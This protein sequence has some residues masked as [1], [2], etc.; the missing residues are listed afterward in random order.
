MRSILVVLLVVGF[1]S[2]GVGAAGADPA[3]LDELLSL[4]A[5]ARGGKARFEALRALRLELQ[6]EEATF[7][8]KGIYVA[9]KDG[10]MRVDIYSG[11]RRVFTEALGPQ[12][13]WQWREGDGEV[14]RLTD[15]AEGALRRGLVSNLYASYQWPEQGYRLSLVEE[16]KEESGSAPAPVLIAEESDGFTRQLRIDPS[17]HRVDR[18]YETSALHPDLD[19]AKTA[20]YSVTRE[21]MTVE[22]IDIPRSIEKIDEAS[23][24]V[25]QRSTVL[26]ASLALA[27]RA[28]P[29]WARPAQFD[30][31]ALPITGSP[32]D[33]S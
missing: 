12:G 11:D 21:W 17:T 24:E 32:G 29:A 14:S 10:Y 8:V 20:Q 4:N 25:I 22:G 33:R 18:A 7:E 26:A 19:P 5:K 3:R 15:V 1:L 6:L 28:L 27:D 16:R 30:P 9:T 13:G 2:P 31:G 23:G